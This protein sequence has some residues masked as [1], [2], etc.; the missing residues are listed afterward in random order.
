MEEIL[1]NLIC[2]EYEISQEKL[3][4]KSRE[5]DI[6]YPLSM[7]AY[8][9]HVRFNWDVASVHSFFK[10]K[11]YLKTRANLYNLLKKSSHN[12]QF[13]G[14]WKNTYDSLVCGIEMAQSIGTIVEKEDYLHSVR[15]RIT[16]KLFSIQNRG[17]LDKVEF[18]LDKSLQS[19]FITEGQYEKR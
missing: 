17:N 7:M 13:F 12:I 16:A 1:L 14:S 2:Q 9:L 10:K 15:G 4:S 19:E 8:I 18:L 5:E 3:F 11:G 6:I